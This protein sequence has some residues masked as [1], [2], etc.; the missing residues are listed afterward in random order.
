[1][2]FIS[3]DPCI[4]CN[5]F[6]VNSVCFHHLYTRKA[7]RELENVKWNMIPVCQRCHN[8]FHNKGTK[9]MADKFISV[10]FWLV[11]NGWEFC[12]ISKKWFHEK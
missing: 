11:R 9:V 5:Y 8:L 3:S 12:E 2:K 6:Q 7:H 4:A 10:H 1:M